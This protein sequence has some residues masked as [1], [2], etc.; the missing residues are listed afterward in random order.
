MIIGQ[1]LDLGFCRALKLDGSTC[2]KVI[3]V[4]QDEFC[5]YHVVQEYQR[6]KE[7]RQEFASGFVM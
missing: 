2:S 5:E 3:N 1:A 7:K 4:A 6:K